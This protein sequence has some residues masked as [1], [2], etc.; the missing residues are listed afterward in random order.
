[1]ER[2]IGVN[3]P[4]RSYN[5]APIATAANASVNAAPTS[6]TRLRRERASGLNRT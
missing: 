5:K 2:S 4:V 6:A 3:A 1:M